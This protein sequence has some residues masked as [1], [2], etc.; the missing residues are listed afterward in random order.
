MSAVP[1]KVEEIVC[2]L[3]TEILSGQYRVGERLPS[4][5]DLASRFESNRGGIREVIK[6]LEQ[7]GI[8]EV[9]P[10]GVRVR[11][12][13]EATLEVLGYLLELG[14][15]QKPDLFAQVLDVLGAMFSLSVRSAID[16]ATDEDISE[17]AT[18]IEGLIESITD[19]SVEKHHELWMTLTEKMIAVHQ[20]LV[21]K[22]IGNGLRTRFM[23]GINSPDFEPVIDQE[24]VR[25]VLNDLKNAVEEKNSELAGRAIIR[26]FDL[27][28]SGLVDFSEQSA[29]TESQRRTGHA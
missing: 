19:D 10:G 24:A 25:Q 22:L 15:I 16:R 1:S 5:R 13:E 7:L 26:H 29:D 12:V 20:N 21:L 23:A 18:I 11:P 3:R 4:E 8:I 27:M 14:E 6:K 9:T 28:K 17:I 2:T